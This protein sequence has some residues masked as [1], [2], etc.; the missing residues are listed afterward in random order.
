MGGQAEMGM[1]EGLIQPMYQASSTSRNT[2]T[3]SPT[4]TAKA[5][6][7]AELRLPGSDPLRS[8]KTP[9]PARATSTATSISTMRIF[10][11]EE[12]FTALAGTQSC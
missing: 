2:E 12:Y 3:E 9:A 6:A 11:R 7:M 10:M 1:P 8:M 5:R 4:R